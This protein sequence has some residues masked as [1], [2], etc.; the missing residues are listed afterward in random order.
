MAAIKNTKSK[1]TVK[2][3]TSPQMTV[4][5]K[6]Y[7]KRKETKQKTGYTRDYVQDVSRSARP[8]GRRIS[9]YGNIYYEYRDNRS[10]TEKEMYSGLSTLDEKTLK[11]FKDYGIRYHGGELVTPEDKRSTRK[12][13]AK[14]LNDVVKSYERKIHR[15]PIENLLYFDRCGNVI[16]HC[17]GNSGSVYI[18]VNCENNCIINTHNHPYNSLRPAPQSTAD[19]ENFLRFDSPIARVCSYGVTYTYKKGPNFDEDRIR[20]LG[21]V[22]AVTRPLAK[23]LKAME[24]D[25]FR[26]IGKYLGIKVDFETKGGRIVITFKNINNLPK[27]LYSKAIDLAQQMYRQRFGVA[28]IAIHKSFVESLRKH[29][30]D[31]SF[32]VG[33]L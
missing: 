28:M 15:R 6:P 13:S 12:L 22:K 18:N 20:E 5:Q 21:G 30:V 26:K 23:A 16:A 17:V 19:V 7:G 1:K 4:P 2:D 10:D 9:R 29:G 14:A 11:V 31:I 3:K 25:L 33:G 32:T 27:N 24:K 8:V